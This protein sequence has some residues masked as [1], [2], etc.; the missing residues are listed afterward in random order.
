MNNEI[1]EPLEEETN[2]PGCERHCF[3][4]HLNCNR[5][6][7]HFGQEPVEEKAPLSWAEKRKLA[8]LKNKQ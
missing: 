7:A 2:C 3:R 8:K 6:R 5:G 4:E 1:K